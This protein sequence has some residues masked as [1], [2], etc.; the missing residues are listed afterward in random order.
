MKAS[1]CDSDAK[2][3]FW[4]TKP[5]VIAWTSLQIIRSPSSG[6]HVL[7]TYWNERLVKIAQTPWEVVEACFTNTGT[8]SDHP[9]SHPLHIA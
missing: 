4:S 3:G 9:S 2:P 1:S 8:A 7:C 5:I 6:F